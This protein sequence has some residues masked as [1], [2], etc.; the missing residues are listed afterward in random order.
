MDGVSHA[1]V[2]A[3]QG[4]VIG[5]LLDK[6]FGIAHGHTD[7]GGL[8]GPQ[9]IFAVADHHH[10][11]P[12]KVQMLQQ[13][14]QEHCV[15]LLERK[16]RKDFAG[17]AGDVTAHTRAVME[18]RKEIGEFLEKKAEEMRQ[19]CHEDLAKIRQMLEDAPAAEK[20]KREY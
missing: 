15:D 4:D 20:D 6:I 11:L 5:S 10:V 16:S 13:L 8:D 19:L 9:V 17:L 7:L 14:G 3:V 18:N 2:V 1:R 12:P